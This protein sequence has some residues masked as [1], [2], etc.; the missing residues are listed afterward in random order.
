MLMNI[1]LV[2]PVVFFLGSAKEGESM[3]LL[4]AISSERFLA[5]PMYNKYLHEPHKTWERY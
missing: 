3:M 2:T 4:L 1:F 5:Y